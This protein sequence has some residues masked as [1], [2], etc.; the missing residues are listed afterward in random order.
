MAELGQHERLQPFLLDRLRDEQPD[1]QQESRDQR[2][3][4]LQKYRQAVIRDI[5]W[6]LNAR[7]CMDEQ[8]SADYPL[9][10]RSVI[11]FGMPDITGLTASSLSPA[12]LEKLVKSA[13]ETFEPRIIPGSLTVSFVRSADHEANTLALEIRGTIWA[14][15]VPESL[16]IKTEVD[17]ETGDCTL[18]T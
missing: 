7:M 15:P 8:E 10:A 6:L 13:I 12:R 3:F 14:L 1:V 4:N 17:L 5:A 16:Y 18:N 11:N 9:V 2:V